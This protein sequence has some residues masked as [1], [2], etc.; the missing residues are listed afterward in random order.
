MKNKY[1]IIFLFCFIFNGYSFAE[2]FNFETSEIEIIEEG[3]T[4]LAKEG[5]AISADKNLEI[6]A[7]EF[8]YFKKLD[9]LIKR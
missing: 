5:K 9:L 4:I 2:P 7:V 6:Q 1:L 8:K 3:N